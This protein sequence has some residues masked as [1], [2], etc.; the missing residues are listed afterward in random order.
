MATGRTKPI[1]LHCE[2]PNGDPVQVIAKFSGGCDRSETALAME[3][4]AACL[5]SDLAIPVA[6]PVL[7][8][9]PV[10]W[11]MTIT[12]TER[13]AMLE[14]SSATAF[15]SVVA[16]PQFTQWL[17]TMELNDDMA[18]TAAAI[19]TFDAI[20]QN[21]DRRVANPNCLVRGTEFR[22]IDH[23]L[24]FSHGLTL[25]W[26]P[27]WVAGSLNNLLPREAHI[28][29][30]AL[31]ARQVDWTII[32]DTWLALSDQMIAD[33]EDA[34]PDEWVRAMPE[35]HRALDLIRSARA[36]IE[37]CIAEVRRVLQ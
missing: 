25:G 26:S 16:G 27:P 21:P 19:F 28:F 23:E 12:D 36:N 5:A 15:G 29:R 31:V 8:D 18:Q 10:D 35:V 4:V 13:R 11:A 9:V 14:R 34:V 20:I 32:R 24:A 33:Y 1:L 17:P 6:E 30:G 7:V 3:A 2:Y 22:V 37:G